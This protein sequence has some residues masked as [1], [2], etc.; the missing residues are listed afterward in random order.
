MQVA[1]EYVQYGVKYKYLN[2][3]VKRL[4]EIYVA[5]KSVV[6]LANQK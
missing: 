5:H 2:K 3:Y 1:K 4:H 6:N